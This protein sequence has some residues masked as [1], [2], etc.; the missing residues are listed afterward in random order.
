MGI[1]FYVRIVGMATIEELVKQKF[2]DEREK[3]VVSLYVTA[4]LMS[5]NSEKII[6]RFGISGA[7]LNVLRILREQYPHPSSIQTLKERIVDQNTDMSRMITRLLNDGLAERIRNVANP[8]SKSV[9]ISQKGLDILTEI[10]KHREELLLPFNA[11]SPEETKQ[12][13]QLLGKLLTTLHP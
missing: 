12:L 5:G 4:N 7:R 2:P 9:I 8:R 13:G 10:D 11:L 1:I 6:E 3:A